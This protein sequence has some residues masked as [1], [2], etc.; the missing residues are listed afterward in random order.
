MGMFGVSQTKRLNGNLNFKES[1]YEDLLDDQKA[2]IHVLPGIRMKHNQYSDDPNQQSFSE[3]LDLGEPAHHI[4]ERQ[5][6]D[7]E[8]MA[9]TITGTEEQN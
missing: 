2:T 9:P 1:D 4:P 8:M 6:Q 7:Q 3:F 5:T